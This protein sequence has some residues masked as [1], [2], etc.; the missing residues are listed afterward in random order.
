M[1]VAVSLNTTAHQLHWDM[2]V[3]AYSS[4]VPS[5]IWLCSIP[6]SSYTVL[7]LT[8]EDG[9]QKIVSMATN[10]CLSVVQRQLQVK[11]IDTSL[12][13]SRITGLSVC[14][15]CVWCVCVCV[16]CVWCVCVCVCVCGVCVRGVC[17]CVVCVCGCVCVCVG[18]C[19]WVCVCVCGCV[20][21]GVCVCVSKYEEKCKKCSLPFSFSFPLATSGLPDPDL[22]IV[23]GG[24]NSTL[25][26]PPWQM[27]LT[28]IL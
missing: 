22:A 4:W 14:V 20:C 6:G 10:I 24:V 9:Q 7:V 3:H 11:D 15:W 12:V 19:V 17:G 18:V 23:F 16:V 5:L 8:P 13:A 1:W 26:F 28:E 25:G 2:C 21:V 27:R